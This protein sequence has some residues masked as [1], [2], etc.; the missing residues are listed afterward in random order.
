M[1]RCIVK[2][3]KSSTI[4]PKRQTFPFPDA[5]KLREKWYRAIGR[6]E[7]TSKRNHRICLHHFAPDVVEKYHRID[8]R[9]T[10]ISLKKYR[11]HP[12]AV[13]SIF[14]GEPHPHPP[15]VCSTNSG[16]F[17][18][19]CFNKIFLNATDPEVKIETDPNPIELVSNPEETEV[20]S[21]CQVCESTEDL[22][23]ISA[24]SNALYQE[25]LRKIIKL[26]N[27]EM[28]SFF[29]FIC[30]KCGNKL[31]D[32][33]AFRVQY[34]FTY[35]RLL[36]RFVKKEIV[37]SRDD[38][39]V[40]EIGDM[41]DMEEILENDITEDNSHPWSEDTEEIE[42]REELPDTFGGEEEETLPGNEEIKD[43]A[44]QEDPENTRRNKKEKSFSSEVCQMN[45]KTKFV[46]WRI[47]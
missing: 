28:N 42:D 9:L 11:L 4:E 22:I 8:G 13:P 34:E 39:P 15:D 19:T 36:E 1:V 43:L 26:E 21:F 38:P 27:E 41:Q 23:D 18:E 30:R 14:P 32:L 17:N 10:N 7:V 44:D 2:G 16:N 3:C 25:E 20:F 33:M 31:E 40:E 6:P 45:V 46:L 12:D 5:P 24:P 37:E 47:K 29:K 35:R